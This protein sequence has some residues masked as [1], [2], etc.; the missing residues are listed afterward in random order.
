MAFTKNLSLLLDFATG[1]V[2]DEIWR[3]DLDD[4]D[5]DGDNRKGGCGLLWSCGEVAG[6]GSKVA[7]MG[8]LGR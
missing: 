4:D 6:E 1:D 8:W 5:D 3:W 2:G 7:V